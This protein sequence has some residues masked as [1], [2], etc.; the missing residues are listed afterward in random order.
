MTK[1][2]YWYDSYLKEF[3]ARVIE[4]VENKIVLDQTIFHPR[5][6][7][8]V[9]DIGKII[10]KGEEYNV[11]DVYKENNKIYHVLDKL[12]SFNIGDII[13]GII[14]WDRRYRLMRLHTAA[15]II[16]A[17]LYRDYNAFVTGGEITPDY[18]RDDYSISSENWKN[19][20]EDAIRKAN[21][22]IKMGIPVKIYFL[23]R[24]EAM[25][26]P[27]IIKLLE[28]APPDMEEWR[29]V[30]IENIDIQADGGPHVSNTKEIGE[31]KIMKLEN[32]GKNKKR[33]YFTLK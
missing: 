14:D 24:E 16:S 21:D 23:K 25:K 6:G 19:A 12:P 27:G 30:E 8:V 20:F 2:L 22:I 1:L 3:N 18:G 11:I 31:I 26:I 28:R 15:H 9:N 17:I 5:S 33:L 7:G 32:R 10:Y 13:Y 29:I 4:I